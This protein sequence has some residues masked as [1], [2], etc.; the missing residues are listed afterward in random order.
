MQL[1][2]VPKPQQPQSHSAEHRQLLGVYKAAKSGQAPNDARRPGPVPAVTS[3][4][5]SESSRPRAGPTQKECL[6]TRLRQAMPRGRAL[7]TLGPALL[8]LQL[9]ARV[10]GSR[11]WWL[12]GLGS[13]YPNASPGLRFDLMAVTLSHAYSCMSCSPSKLAF[14]RAQ[15]QSMMPLEWPGRE[16]LVHK[17]RG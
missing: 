7:G 8:R 4:L 15:A 17:F 10:P 1:Q 14:G 9:P 6:P 12:T 5:A 3:S 13:H 11:Q 16:S 2:R